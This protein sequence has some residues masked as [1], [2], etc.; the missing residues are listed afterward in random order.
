LKK[1]AIFLAVLLISLSVA[2]VASAERISPQTDIIFKDSD[3][4][5]QTIFGPGS[6]YFDD[7]GFA[8]AARYVMV[9]GSWPVAK[10]G[11]MADA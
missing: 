1:I 7:G 6:F 4:V 11:A 9:N 8:G 5:Y 2:G 10:L 3:G